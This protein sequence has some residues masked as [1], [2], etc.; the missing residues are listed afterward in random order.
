MHLRLA[1][2]IAHTPMDAPLLVLLETY[3]TNPE[4]RQPASAFPLS[5]R[6]AGELSRGITG[7]LRLAQHTT[8]CDQP[9]GSAQLLFTKLVEAQRGLSDEEIEKFL[10]TGRK[11][12]LSES[13]EDDQ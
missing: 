10:A 8:W 11:P 4:V 13:A 9:Q 12:D 6:Q 2:N 7:L 1:L 3:D 5:I